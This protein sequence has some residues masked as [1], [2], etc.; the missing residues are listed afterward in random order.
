MYNIKKF[1]NDFIKIWVVVLP[2]LATVTIDSRQGK[3]NLKTPLHYTN[4][5]YEQHQHA[6]PLLN[7]HT[8]CP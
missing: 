7:L 4:T 5:D 8:V 6:H 3:A 2:G 1:Q